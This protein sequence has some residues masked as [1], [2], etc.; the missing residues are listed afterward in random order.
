MSTQDA[1]LLIEQ[2]FASKGRTPFSHQ[3]EAWQA[4]LRSE[5]GIVHVPTGAGKTYSAFLGAL[6]H[7]LTSSATGL[8]ILYVTPLKAVSRDVRL[9]LEEPVRELDLGYRVEDRTGDTSQADRA[10]QRKLLPEVLVTTPESLSLLLTHEAFIESISNL[11]TVIVD[12]WHELIGS[13]RG[14]LLELSLARLRS[15]RPHLATWALTATLANVE[16]AARVVTGSDRPTVV[17][18]KIERPLVIETVLP[19]TEAVDAFPW[20]GQWGVR[21]ARA[22]VERL[23]AKQSTLIFTNT[24]SQAER[25]FQALLDEKP[26]WAPIT[27]LHHGSLDALERS[28]VESGVKSGEIRF[29]VCTS[30]LDLG[31]DFGLVERVVQI[32]SPKSIGRLLQR[33]GR[34]AHRPGATAKILFVPT[35]S[36]ELVEISALRDAVA[37]GD[38]E[39]R[40]PVPAPLDVLV[41]HLVTRALGGGFTREEIA[42]EIRSARSFS[43]VSD[44]DLDWALSFICDGGQSLTAYPAYRKVVV[45]DG[46]YR[47]RD[48]RIARLHRLN[49][50]TI[51][52]SAFVK[53]KFQRGREIGQI[54]ETFAAKLKPGDRFLFGGRILEFITLRDL[55]AIVKMGK[56]S[57]TTAPSW[58]GG[59]LPYSE[60]LARHVR[61]TLATLNERNDSFEAKA[62][63]PLVRQQLSA[64][65]L[66]RDGE[67]LV[68]RLE[69]Q[70]GTH[71]FLYTFEGR[72]LNESLAA[73]L[74]LRFARKRKATF[75]L[76][77]ND[78][79][80]EILSAG[81][82]PFEDH[83]S[84]ELFSSASLLEDLTEALHLSQ[85][86]RGVFRDVARV[87]GLLH[88]GHPS[89]RKSARQLQASAGL[90]FDVL[91]RYEPGHPLLAQAKK[92][93]LGEILENGRLQATLERLASSRLSLHVTSRPTPLAF[94]LL[95]D[96][97]SAR[98]SNES[99]VDRINRMKKSWEVS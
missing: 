22:L 23:D 69:S 74:A 53:L 36:L 70:E 81:E 77:S 32:G 44:V 90:L 14:S 1:L 95:T 62:L 19:Q 61:T 30:S 59:R 56:G 28:R 16:E 43:S 42:Q 46:V 80:L 85:L 45:E 75:S 83:L 3:R 87:A 84:K 89:V 17:R 71:L 26:D 24:R 21:Q 18:S 20:S 57:A 50:G 58:S 63:A 91:S 60:P 6:A 41:Q 4:R 11:E 25:W 67:T 65:A 8:R 99:L 73:L 93:V 5:S 78:Y 96:R 9:A 12:E 37:C 86:A 49:V 72:Q 39:P 48:G 31:V 29:V 40:D 66:P 7:S 88:P 98:L 51:E 52:S 76:S 97:L 2:W 94:P 10:R 13:K 68:E 15:A 92:Q 35:H 34:S 38:V 27:A 64:S 79:G 82:F 55:D 54:E 47:V 33:A